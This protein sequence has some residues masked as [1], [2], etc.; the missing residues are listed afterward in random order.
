MFLKINDAYAIES[1]ST[2]WAVSKYT[3]EPKRGKYWKQ[4]AW[5]STLE[6]ATNGLLQR[7]IRCLEVDNLKDAIK[8][9]EGCA[10][11]LIGALSPECEVKLKEKSNE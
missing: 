7:E 8:A 3:V 6:S 5:Y 4:I 11:E 9:V 1:N 2:G 10:T